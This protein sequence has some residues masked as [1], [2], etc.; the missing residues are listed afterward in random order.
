MERKNKSFRTSRTIKP[1]ST[2]TKTSTTGA[3][4]I[5]LLTTDA[6]NRYN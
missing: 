3:N 2:I 5:Y 4:L 6:H 1:N